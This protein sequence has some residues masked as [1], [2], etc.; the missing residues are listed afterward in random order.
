MYGLVLF[1]NIKEKE[2]VV[3]N[4]QGVI[5]TKSSIRLDSEHPIW[6][7]FELL[8]GLDSAEFPKT[9]SESSNLIGYWC[10]WIFRPW[11][12]FLLQIEAFLKVEVSFEGAAVEKKME[13]KKR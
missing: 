7:E 3:K 13:R 5:F 6:L 8:I 2:L 4:T 9:E 11:G 1:I 10:K 12:L